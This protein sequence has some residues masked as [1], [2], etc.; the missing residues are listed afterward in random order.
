MTRHSSLST[1]SPT[2]WPYPVVEELDVVRVEQE[3]PQRVAVWARP[4]DLL[5]EPQ[6]PYMTR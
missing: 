2:S 3:E 5:E 6:V 1:A 4:R